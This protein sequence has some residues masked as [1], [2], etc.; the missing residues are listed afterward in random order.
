MKTTTHFGYQTVAAEA[1]QGKVN[2]VFDNVAWRYDIMNDVMSGGLHRGWKNRMVDAIPRKR[3]LQALDLA[4]GT[5]DIAFRMLS[6]CGDKGA[7][8]TVTDINP[9]MLEEGKKRALNRN[10]PLE[11]LQWKI[12]NAEKL[13]F[14][15]KKYDV[16]TMA[17]GIR[18]VTHIDLVLAEA[19]R[20]LK[21]CGKFLCLEFSPLDDA[22]WRKKFYDWYSFH[23]IPAYGKLFTGNEAAYKYLVESIRMFPDRER[24]A[25]MMKETGFTRVKYELMSGGVVALHTGYRT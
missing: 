17:F 11:Q 24:F 15:D 9:A 16:V 12:A 8:I 6:R 2:E 18:N 1:K 10:L 7:K 23:I 3:D 5:G 19:F 13:P 4:G 22:N 25:G 14:G 20:V 21:P